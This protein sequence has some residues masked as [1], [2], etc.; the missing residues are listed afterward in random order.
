[1]EQ[2]S[3]DEK[4]LLKIG[5]DFQGVSGRTLRKIPFLAHMKYLKG[6]FTN[7]FMHTQNVIK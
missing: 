1:M 5:E 6:W 3:T 2:W 4:E 7:I